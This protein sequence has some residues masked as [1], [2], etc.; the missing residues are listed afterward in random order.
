MLEQQSKNGALGGFVGGGHGV[1]VATRFA[2]FE[3]SSGDRADV[4]NGV[5]GRGGGGDREFE[6][7]HRISLG[8]P[9]APEYGIQSS[10]MKSLALALVAA[11]AAWASFPPTE[12]GFVV[13]AVVPLLLL[14]VLS[15]PTPRT[16]IAAGLLFGVTFM[17]LLMSWLSALGIEAMIGL[18][19][20][21]ALWY[22]L[23]AR[24][25]WKFRD[26]TSATLVT[27]AVGGWTAM[28]FGRAR[29]PAGGLN[30]GALGYPLGEWAAYRSLSQFVGAT[31]LEVLLVLVGVSL[32]MAA[33][34]RDMRLVVVAV[35]VV[36]AAVG[37]GGFS[38]N[39]PAGEV[40]RVAIVQ[41]NSP[42][43]RTHCP[44]ERQQI[45]ENH[46]RLTSD[47]DAGSVDLI[48][49]A[50]SSST[51]PANASDEQA[52]LVADEARRIGATLVVGGDR[53][54]T[55][56]TFINSNVIF[57]PEGRIVGEYL[58]NHP[59]PFGEYVPLR[60]IFGLIPATDQVPRDMVRG[61]GPVVVDTPFGQ[62]GTVIS[63]EGAFARYGR[64]SVAGG[65]GLLL[66]A[67][68]ESSYGD[69]PAA[70]QFI[71]M[72]RMRAAEN[73][74]DVVHGAVTGSS[75]II[76][77]GGE[78][79]EQSGLFEEAVVTGEVQMRTAAPT[80]YTKWGDWLAVAAMVAGAYVFMIEAMTTLAPS[81]RSAGN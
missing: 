17:S 21:Q 7:G 36:V 18:M 80:L 75:V 77:N 62:I 14:S 31:G 51:F 3:L 49:W 67:S 8:A 63:F 9:C 42:C 65:A 45:F 81:R 23:W 10:R 41:G 6:V 33:L 74:V 38:N 68:N 2:I 43:P 1:D 28:E 72:T 22:P 73:G 70:A 5:G 58:K 64:S 44:N 46:L 32:V 26:S 12:L 29:L 79:G 52:Q 30:W 4:G 35:G 55:A 69:S 11:L 61:D 54:G 15:A 34:R 47:I 40:V 57:S 25:V 71:G 59:V 39:A 19:L 50:E 66:V 27:I 48:L 53:G 60:P 20:S 24:V 37:V 16:A 76:T 78:L 13:V 56:T